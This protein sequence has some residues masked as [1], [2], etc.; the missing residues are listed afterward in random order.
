M[1]FSHV[2][3]LG[4]PGM[5]DVGSKNATLREALAQAVVTLPEEVLRHAEGGDILGSK[6]PVFQTAII[7]A[8][9]AAKKTWDLIPLCH[10]IAV[11]RCSIDIRLLGKDAVIQARFACH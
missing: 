6:G 7:A 9:Q 1:P 10:P 5:V 2:N 8:T 11:A 3:P 4:Q